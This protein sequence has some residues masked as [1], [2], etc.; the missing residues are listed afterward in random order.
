MKNGPRH[1]FT[2]LRRGRPFGDEKWTERTVR[3]LGLEYTVR[4]EGRPTKE[5]R[6]KGP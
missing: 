2:S 5:P 4:R 3:N 1:R 6:G